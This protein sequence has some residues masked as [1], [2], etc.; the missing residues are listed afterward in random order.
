MMDDFMFQGGA[1]FDVT[2]ANTETY[3]S[4]DTTVKQIKKAIKEKPSSISV[5]NGR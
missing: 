3:F 1:T 5:F 2:S 4:Y